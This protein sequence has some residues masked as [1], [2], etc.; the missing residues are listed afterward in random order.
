MMAARVARLAHRWLALAVGLQLVIWTA[1]GLYMTSVDLDL[2]HGDPLVRNL[3][4]GLAPERV[5]VAPAAVLAGREGVTRLTLR[6]LPDGAAVYEL[7]GPGGVTPVDAQTG[8]TRPP[9]TREAAATLARS[10]YAGGGALANLQLLEGDYP[11]EIRGRTSPVWR[12]DFDDWLA[13]S[14]YVDPVTG[15]LVTRRHRLWRWFDFLWSLHIMDYGE[16][17]NVN[18]ALLRGVT[19]AGLA[20]VASGLWLTAYAFRWG[21]RRRTSAQA[22]TPAPAD[23]LAPAPPR[24]DAPTRGLTLPRLRRLHRWVAVIVGAQLLLWSVSGATFA[25]LDAAEVAGER[26]LRDA[27]P[28]ALPAGYAPVDPRGWL[29]G[30][31]VLEIRLE[32]LGDRWVYRVDGNDGVRLHD[33]ATGRR[34]TV[35]ATMARALA[36]ERHAGDARIVDVVRHDA[37]ALEAREHGAAWAVRYD[38][39]DATTLWISADDGRVLEARTDAWRLRD[40]FWMLHTMDYRG[41]DDFNNALVVLFATASLWVTLTGVLL[42]TRVFGRRWSAAA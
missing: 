10:Y 21:R 9:L 18:N 1:S 30:A 20:F 42:L 12:A 27:E 4:T 22:T 6:A 11:Q 29:G 5:R 16:R 7:R 38:D 35:D 24:V 25:W 23:A 36:A 28:R 26:V 32:A 13:T 31:P 39:E 40:T 17:E 34:V 33:A 19:L 2:I 14:L 8:R 37:G 15:R 41:R 3:R